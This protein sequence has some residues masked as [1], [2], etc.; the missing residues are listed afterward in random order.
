MP[1]FGIPS[2][3]PRDALSFAGDGHSYVLLDAA[4][5]LGGL[6]A[7]D[8]R[9][10]EDHLGTCTLCKRAVS[11]LSGMPALLSRID[12]ADVAAIDDRGHL[13]W[14]AP[15]LPATLLTSVVASV[16]RRQRRARLKRS[17]ITAAAGAVL[18]IGAF[19]V[20]QSHFAAAP[21]EL[22]Q[23]TAG[24]LAMTPVTPSAIS[25]T[26]TL[27]SHEW[28]TGIEMNCAYD[29]APDSTR[30]STDNTAGESLA[31]VVVRRDGTSTQLAT[32]DGLTGVDA[33]PRGSTSTPMSQ[34]AA[35]Q[36]V[37]IETGN[38]LLQLNL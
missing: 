34:I 24:A 36:V 38:V 14:A 15:A 22:P 17:M 29:V 33:S 37:S 12:A 25:A 20:L 28:G 27:S 32:W 23:A 5:V 4:Y 16:T 10:F 3:P 26:V 13:P 1:Q 19:L 21:P 18:M 2:M 30:R 8:R 7:S 31:M 35:V 6:S 9:D 11:E